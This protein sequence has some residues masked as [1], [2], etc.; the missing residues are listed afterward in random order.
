[1]LKRK[2][3][4]DA[5]KPKE[6]KSRPTI[7]TTTAIRSEQTPIRTISAASPTQEANPPGAPVPTDERLPDLL[8]DSL[9]LKLDK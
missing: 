6:K 2:V 8:D 5:N 1:M 9:K 7:I 3:D 4:S